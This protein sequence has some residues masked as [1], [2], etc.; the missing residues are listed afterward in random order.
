MH[1]KKFKYNF[2]WTDTFLML[3]LIVM[4]PT[5]FYDKIYCIAG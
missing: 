2:M 1:L 5:S 4:L 3:C